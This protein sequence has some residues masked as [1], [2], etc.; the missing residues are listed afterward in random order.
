MFISENQN[1]K[2]I[3][4]H[5]KLFFF[6]NI[7]EVHFGLN[8]STIIEN[9]KI[10]HTNSIKL[11]N[12]CNETLQNN[13]CEY[14]VERLQYNEQLIDRDISFL[15]SHKNIRKKR[16][17]IPYAI[18]Y[19][20]G[21]LSERKE[22]L[23]KE[24]ETNLK[25]LEFLEEQ[26]KVM[27]K[28]IETTRIT[29]LNIIEVIKQHEEKIREIEENIQKITNFYDL[30]HL[31]STMLEDHRHN[32]HKLQNFWGNSIQD[33]LFLITDVSNFSDQMYLINNTL[34]KDNM[35]PPLNPYELINVAKIK[36]HQNETHIVIIV[37]IPI[38]KKNHLLLNE[39]IPVPL[40]RNNKTMI[41]DTDSQFFIQS[42]ETEFLILPS[43]VLKECVSHS[44]ITIC[45]SLT[46][47]TLEA[48][49]FCI[50]KLLLENNDKLCAYKTIFHKNYFIKIS[51]TSVYIH[52]ID[53][54][55]L[56][57]QCAGQESILELKE[58]R[59]VSFPEEC[60]I[61][62]YSD[63]ELNNSTVFT[64]DVQEPF[65]QVKI[66]TY[67]SSSNE[68]ITDIEFLEKED[69]KFIEL[70]NN[71][72]TL[73]KYLNETRN[74]LNETNI[75]LN[76]TITD[77]INQKSGS[78]WSNIKSSYNEI[79]NTFSN[80]FGGL[81]LKLLIGSLQYILLPLIILYFTFVFVKVFISRLICR[82]FS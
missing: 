43:E 78:L 30:L 81:A 61:L 80:V 67:N 41:I 82:S 76:R 62:K 52:V 48:P 66:K 9:A 45:N 14:F 79:S 75:T 59:L 27:E 49:D 23:M 18:G 64:F 70:L 20:F 46:E 57:S 38:L 4:T 55:L 47:N 73:K 42:K 22:S 16:F 56:K 2:I 15:K 65:Y 36:L 60:E 39:F 10:L 77:P 74:E 69:L 1:G 12:M 51:T 68:W 3:T 31:T 54:I 71:T 13:N 7:H 25:R 8:I 35:L 11:K 32:M 5:G 6:E 24:R 72:H 34:T 50:K 44:N 63:S 53:P 26:L 21:K 40:L 33:Q 29:L 37:K 58:S 19:M 28:T 17:I